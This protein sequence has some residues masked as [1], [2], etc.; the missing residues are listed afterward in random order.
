MY[1]VCTCIC[2]QKSDT[3]APESALFWGALFACPLLWIF[4]LF[5][6]IIKLHWEWAVRELTIIMLSLCRWFHHLLLSL[7]LSF[8]LSLPPSLPPSSLPLSPSLLPPSSLPRSPPPSFQIIPVIG[9][10]LTGANVIGYVK[11]RRDAGAKL[12]QMAGQFI[13]QQIMKEVSASSVTNVKLYTHTQNAE[14]THYLAQKQQLYTCIIQL[15]N[16]RRYKK[17]KLSLI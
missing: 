5:T 8:S 6:A 15:S 4:C 17:I 10:S 13:G 2:V 7:S 1:Q 3:S 9:I 11:C 16:H 12:T 14:L